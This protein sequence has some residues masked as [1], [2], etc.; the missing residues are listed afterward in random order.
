MIAACTKY[1]CKFIWPCSS[2]VDIHRV[3][4]ISVIEVSALYLIGL[5]VVYPFLANNL[6]TFVCIDI[7][8]LCLFVFLCF[9]PSI[10]LDVLSIIL[11]EDWVTDKSPRTIIPTRLSMS[12][13]ITKAIRLLIVPLNYQYN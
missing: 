2:L 4:W 13:W 3:R 9:F 6:D 11:L 7:R 5:L 8:S 12:R 10:R 1:S